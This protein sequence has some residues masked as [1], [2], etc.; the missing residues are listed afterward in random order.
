M[1]PFRK[2]SEK[3]IKRAEF[4]ELR[5][6]V[7]SL[8]VRLR[9]LRARHLSSENEADHAATRSLVE[10][11]NAVLADQA[12]VATGINADRAELNR[13]MLRRKGKTRPWDSSPR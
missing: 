7:A 11:A 6:E 9:K 13:T 10:Q 8:T 5:D 3:Y 1:W 12:N 2:D 4:E